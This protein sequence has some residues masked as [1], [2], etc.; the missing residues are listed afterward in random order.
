MEN[1]FKLAAFIRMATLPGDNSISSNQ[2][3]Q[4]TSQALQ[5]ARTNRLRNTVIYPQ[6][7]H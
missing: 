5:H 3:L 4:S 1:S 6:I 7:K 2:L